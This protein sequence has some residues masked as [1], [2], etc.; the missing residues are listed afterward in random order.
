MLQA[1]DNLDSAQ[2]QNNFRK[3]K[4]LENLQKLFGARERTRT[5]TAFRPLEPESSASANSATRAH[6]AA[7]RGTKIVHA[8]LGFV[9]GTG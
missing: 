7:L 9:N 5:S 3:L 6:S 2:Y 8:G 4:T 1:R